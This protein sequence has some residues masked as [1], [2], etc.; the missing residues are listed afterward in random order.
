MPRASGREREGHWNSTSFGRAESPAVLAVDLL[1][2]ES[3]SSQVGFEGNT[4]NRRLV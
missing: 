3:E 2:Q 1:K 4:A